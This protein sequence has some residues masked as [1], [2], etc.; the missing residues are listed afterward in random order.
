M[1]FW[2]SPKGTEDDELV[3]NP[4]TTEELVEN[5]DIDAEETFEKQKDKIN[6][7]STKM[8]KT[9]PYTAGE[10][11]G[12]SRDIEAMIGDALGDVTKVKNL[13]I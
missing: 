11:I 9:E 2:Y 10:L 13:W 4:R 7:N 1:N 3:G 6:E 12:L 5:Q 8:N